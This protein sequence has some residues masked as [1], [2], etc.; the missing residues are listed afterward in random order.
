MA[1]T[2]HTGRFL[3]C[4]A[5]AALAHGLDDAAFLVQ[6]TESRQHGEPL[7]VPAQVPQILMSSKQG[8]QM[9]RAAATAETGSNIQLNF[10]TSCIPGDSFGSS[11]CSLLWGS[12]VNAIWK[13]H[14][15]SGI[16]P[17]DAIS[18]LFSVNVKPHNT[19]NPWTNLIPGP[20][21]VTGGCQ[22]CEGQCHIKHSK[23]GSF[24]FE[25]EMP[26]FFEDPVECTKDNAKREE[27]YVL[28]NTSWPIPH[29]GNLGLEGNV[30]SALAVKNKTGASRVEGTYV[31]TMNHPL[32]AVLASEQVEA[33]RPMSMM[34]IARKAFKSVLESARDAI[35]SPA[36]K[37]E[38][39]RT[40][41]L[42][43]ENPPTAPTI[44]PHVMVFDVNIKEHADNVGV[45]M[46]FD[47]GCKRKDQA[48]ISC[49]VPTQD[50]FTT[51]TNV[52]LAYE[53]EEG[54]TLKLKIRPKLPG[55]L[56]IMLSGLVPVQELKLPLCGT[57]Q[58]TAMMAGRS[59]LIQ[60]AKCGHY[61]YNLSTL[62]PVISFLPG[63]ADA[64][65][66][67]VAALPFLP[68]HLDQLL[69]AS[70]EILLDF[71]HADNRPILKMDATIGLAKQ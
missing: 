29:F 58:S 62:A 19:T 30:T 42:M 24:F 18:M 22:M 52:S 50:I 68:K 26:T 7:A 53:A 44:T 47:K 1:V 34:G 5:L 32:S 48:S 57:K 33:Q 70:I 41:N 15:A 21:E 65:L 8:F 12:L 11:D 20:F 54:S 36:F 51:T 56:G 69:P 61:S 40:L 16:H 17:G 66:P 59:V 64:D 67:A 6:L 4:V 31:F 2:P 45:N 10:N 71:R 46:W 9:K 23:K 13:A 35:S 28:L 63:F 25:M 43:S 49:R 60:G 38:A 27:D 39:V 3:G 14:V 37:K 55:M